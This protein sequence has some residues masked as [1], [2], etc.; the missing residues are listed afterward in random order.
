MPNV[1][2]LSIPETNNASE[3]QVQSKCVRVGW[4]GL[5]K[6][7]VVIMRPQQKRPGHRERGKDRQKY[8]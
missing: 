7:E 8:R 1:P 4:T 2:H 3:S 5:V 6:T